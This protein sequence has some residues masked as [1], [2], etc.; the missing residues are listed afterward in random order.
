MSGSF[1][2]LVGAPSGNNLQ[3][4]GDPTENFGMSD[5]SFQPAVPVA[6]DL[7]FLEATEF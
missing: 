5:V 1:S 3:Q 6:S 2:D 7:D 4:S